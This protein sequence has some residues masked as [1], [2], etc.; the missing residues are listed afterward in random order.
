L[1][2]VETPAYGVAAVFPVGIAQPRTWDWR[3]ASARRLRRP[4]RRGAGRRRERLRR[5]FWMSCVSWR[6]GTVTTPARRCGRRADRATNASAVW[7]QVITGSRVH[8][9]G[10]VTCPGEV[11]AL[12]NSVTTDASGASQRLSVSASQ[13][14]EMDRDIW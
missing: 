4:R 3:W 13:F 7:P 6:G 2:H 14:D 5:G 11:C 8:A 9:G 10:P 1:P 12:T